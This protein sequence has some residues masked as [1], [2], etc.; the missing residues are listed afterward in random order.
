[1]EDTMK[2]NVL[3]TSCMIA[4]LMLAGLEGQARDRASIRNGRYLV[5]IAGCNDC[6]TKG[7]AFADGRIP[8]SQWLKGD[9][10]GWNGPWGTTWPV[11]LRLL[12]S[13]MSEREWMRTKYAKTRPP[14]PWYALRDMTDR[15]FRDIYR[16]LRHL[17]PAGRPAPAFLPP[18]KIPPE[19]FVRYP[20]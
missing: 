12:A 3:L 14:M 11:N 15:D 8:E 7:Y 19:P 9:D 10:L 20:R 17:G 16:Y 6:H 1:M 4:P 2:R 18:D 5:M 13:S